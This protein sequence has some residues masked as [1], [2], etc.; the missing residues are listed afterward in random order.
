[1]ISED[2]V[3]QINKALRDAEA[4]EAEGRKMGDKIVDD[5]IKAV[6]TGLVSRF[7]SAIGKL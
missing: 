6:Q 5:Y 3:A 7:I 2:T 1:M 4:I